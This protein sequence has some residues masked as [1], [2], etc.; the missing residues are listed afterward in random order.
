MTTLGPDA[1]AFPFKQ[2]LWPLGM[3][4]TTPETDW[5]GHYVMSSQVWMTVRDGSTF[6]HRPLHARCA[7]CIEGAGKGTLTWVCA[8]A[9]R[10][11]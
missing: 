9:C 11:G 4:G 2:V 3:T 6:R 5:Q 1:L 10:W 8:I 7:G